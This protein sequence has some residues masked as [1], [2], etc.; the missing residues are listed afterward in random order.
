MKII[1]LLSL[2]GNSRILTMML[3]AK[4][5]KERA[6]NV[7]FNMVLQVIIKWFQFFVELQ[8][9]RHVTRSCSEEKSFPYSL[10]VLVIVS[11]AK[12]CNGESAVILYGKYYRD[13]CFFG[14]RPIYRGTT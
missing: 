12:I 14:D 4:L 7:S 10:K 3:T 2:F 8:Y 9:L 11:F 5:P 13:C 6:P 1:G